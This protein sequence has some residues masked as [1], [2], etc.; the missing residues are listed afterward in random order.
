[1]AT[2]ACKWLYPE[3]NLRFEATAPWYH[4]VVLSPRQRIVDLCGQLLRVLSAHMKHGEA[5][6]S[7]AKSPCKSQAETPNVFPKK[8]LWM[9]HHW[10]KI[11]WPERPC[12]CLDLRCLSMFFTTCDIMRM[13][14]EGEMEGGRESQPA[15]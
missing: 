9:E 7:T 14:R 15:D 13:R 8:V 11:R 6:E 5:S 2:L 10:A 12:C 3:E 1:M 4:L